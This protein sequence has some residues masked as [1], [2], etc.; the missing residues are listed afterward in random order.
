MNLSPAKVFNEGYVLPAVRL[1]CCLH[2]CYILT[3]L[4]AY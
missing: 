1:D 2:L 3:R 4:K